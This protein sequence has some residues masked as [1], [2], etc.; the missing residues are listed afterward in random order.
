M[1]LAAFDPNL[2]A[3]ASLATNDLGLAFFAFLTLYLLVA[4]HGQAFSRRGGNWWPS[5]S[6]LGLA[7]ASKFSAVS[8]FGVLA[9]VGGG[10][11]LSGNPLRLPARAGAV[12]KKKRLPARLAEAGAAMGILFGLA[13]LVLWASYFFHSLADCGRGL[14]AQFDHQQGGTP[15]VSDGAVFGRRLVVLFPGRPVAE[16]PAAR[17]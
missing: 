2:V 8:L 11:M 7:L 5:A 12:G 9:V 1:A 10:E 4:I 13:F 15:R 17:H 16:D 3:H 6:G 14:T